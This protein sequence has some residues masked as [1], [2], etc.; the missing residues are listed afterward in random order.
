[1]SYT[2]RRDYWTVSRTN[3]LGFLDREPT[4]PEQAARSCHISLIG[5][6][7]VAAPEVFIAD[8]S[9][10]RLEALANRELPHPN[11][12]TS[13]FGVNATGQVAQLRLYDAYARWLRPRLVVLP[14]VYN[15]LADNSNLLTAAA[16]GWR[17]DRMPHSYAERSLNGTIMLIP[18]YH[19]PEKM[20]LRKS[21]PFADT[22]MGEISWLFRSSHILV[23]DLQLLPPNN[24]PW[25][26]GVFDRLEVLKN[27]YPQYRDAFGD[28]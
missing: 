4:S 14:V 8:K 25:A 9:H 21:Q 26:M 10:V 18:P 17:P 3:S 24:N 13:A 11:V 23:Y 7:F 20:P 15:D 22:L 2:N 12:T 1:M 28:W 5:D 19:Q 27:L 16:M 6:S